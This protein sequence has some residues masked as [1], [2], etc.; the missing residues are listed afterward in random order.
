MAIGSKRF[1]TDNKI[2][3][4]DTYFDKTKD[5]LLKNNI[6]AISFW[7][8]SSSGYQ[9]KGKAT[10]HTEGDIFIKAKKW[11]LKSKPNKKVKGVVEVIPTELYSIAALPGEAGKKIV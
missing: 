7:E 5:N 6:V 9:I 3:I 4:I 10:Y 2:W 1:K 8:N 11:I